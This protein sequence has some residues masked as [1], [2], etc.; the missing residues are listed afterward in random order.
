LLACVE[1]ASRPGDNRGVQIPP[2]THY[3]RRDGPSLAYQLFGDGPPLVVAP[4]VPSHLDLMWVDPAYSQVLRRL[5]SFARVLLFDPRGTGLSDPV[6][7]VPTLEEAADDIEAVMDAAGLGRAVIWATVSTC[8]SAALFAARAPNRV[9]AL[10]L[11]MPYAQGTRVGGG[12]DTIVGWDDRMAK[13]IAA[14][15][16]AIEH[17]WGEGRTGGG[18]ARPRWR[19]TAAVVGHVGARFG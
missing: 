12:P 3:L 11:L 1:T 8:P 5:G 10:V 19:A 13:S 9:Q 18:R 14:W 2:R 6:D 15:D 7:H 16:E 17:H 4:S